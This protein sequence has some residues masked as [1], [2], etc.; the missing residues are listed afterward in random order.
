MHLVA[1]PLGRALLAEPRLNV[2]RGA[3][4]LGRGRQILGDPPAH[5][6]S[7]RDGVELLDPYLAQRLHRREVAQF[8]RASA[9]ASAV[10]NW[11]PSAPHSAANA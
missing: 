10:N 4:K 6:I 8:G 11:R 5:R 1:D 7:G 3:D 9:V 2:V